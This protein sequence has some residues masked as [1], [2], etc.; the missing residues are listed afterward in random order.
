MKYAKPENMLNVQVK[1]MQIKTTMR[2]YYIPTQW[3]KFKRLTIPSVD[4]QVEQLACSSIA[5]GEIKQ[6][7][8]FG[9]QFDSF[10]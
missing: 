3:L 8:C 9:S 6:Y 2:Y 7:R 1:H 4:E 10:L 5:G